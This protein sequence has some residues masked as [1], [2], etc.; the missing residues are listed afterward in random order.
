MPTKEQVRQHAE[1]DLVKFIELITEGK[2]VL[3]S[4]HRELLG[5]WT[6]EEAKNHQLVL[7]PRDHQKSALVAY[8]VAW[9]ITRDPTVR[10]LYLSSTSNLAVKQLKFI[11]DILLSD[12]Y[13]YYWPEMIN[14]EESK[15]EKWTEG[16]IAVDHPLRKA[17]AVRDPTIFTAGLTTS[18]TGLH[19]DIAVFD[20]AVVQEN[21][22]TEEGRAK[23]RTQYSLLASIQGV[24]SREWVVGTRYHPNDLYNDLQSMQVEKYNELGEVIGKDDLYEV[25]ERKVENLGDGTG[26]F[27]WP[28]QQ[29]SDGRWFGFNTDILATKRT[30]YLDRTQFRAQYYN[31]P[32]DP[33]N[34]PISR[35]HFQYYNRQYLTRHNGRW[36][37]K[38][39]RLNVFAAVDFAFSL[40]KRADY[41]AIVVLG[42]DSYSNYYILE[43]CRF[44]SNKISEYFNNILKLHQKWD[45]RKIRAEVTHAQDVIVRDLRDNYIRKHG[46]AL[47]IDDFRPT[48]NMGTKDER[49]SAILEPRYSNRQI[50]HYMGGECQTLEEELVSANPAHDDVKDCLASCIDGSVVPSTFSMNYSFNKHMN[51]TSPEQMF[52]S[53]FGGVG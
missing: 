15:R 35:D 53:R 6:R 18:I 41:T 40:A 33:E 37:Y 27:L 31:D 5:W 43:I 51:P 24:E 52:N 34:A 12:T 36:F 10:V 19:C 1:N 11:K 50:W 39:N 20:D 3:G 46:L 9:E 16:E 2:R 26:E 4:V 22:Y 49:I 14:K 48:R 45:F 8:R 7:L 30:K 47:S 25:F 28:R 23:V 17:E 44:K 21:A 32:N 29:R 38:G 42:V 13:R